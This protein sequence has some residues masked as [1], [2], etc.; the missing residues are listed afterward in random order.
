MVAP[1]GVA[2]IQ[3]ACPHQVAVVAPGAAAGAGAAGLPGTTGDA[4]PPLSEMLGPGAGAG[5]GAGAAAGCAAGA[6][7]SD[8][9]YSTSACAADT[10]PASSSV[11]H[12]IDERFMSS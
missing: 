3:A 2:M 4:M 1:P 9:L 8:M 12:K 11:T 7:L 6:F 5:A 10:A